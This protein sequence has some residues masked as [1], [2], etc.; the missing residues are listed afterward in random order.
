MT[1]DP[2]AGGM[3]E[4]V[5]VKADD[6]TMYFAAFGMQSSGER[7]ERLTPQGAAELFWALFIR[8]LQGR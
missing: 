8:P 2:R 4:A 1:D 5:S 6:Q 7:G 3:N